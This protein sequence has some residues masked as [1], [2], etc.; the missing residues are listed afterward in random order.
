VQADGK[1]ISGALTGSIHS[2]AK[3]L[4]NGAPVNGWD[5]WLFIKDGE[6]K[7]INDLR[8]IARRNIPVYD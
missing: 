2:V 8:E 6:K 1:I 5:A 3:S 4:L 7:S